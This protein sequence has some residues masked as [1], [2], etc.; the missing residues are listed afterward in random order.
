MISLIGIVD[1]E[2]TGLD[3]DKDRIVEVAIILYSLVHA[4]PI[5]SFS[6][7][8]P[9]TVHGMEAINHIPQS[10]T[11]IANYCIAEGTFL[12]LVRQSDVIV[13]HNAIFDY[14]FLTSLTASLI[15]DKLKWI[16]EPWICSMNHIEWPNSSSSKALTA[17]ALAHDVGVVSAHRAL[18]DCD[19]LSRLFTRVAEKHS[20][21]DLIEEALKPRKLFKAN[22]DYH[23]RSLASKAG[24]SWHE[25]SRYW[26][27]DETKMWLRQFNERQ[28]NEWRLSNPDLPISC[29]GEI[30]PICQE[31]C[32]D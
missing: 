25:L 13:A 28:F 4:C 32:N 6:S 3:P 12:D 5:A 14:G 7:L 20:L 30:P 2:T 9:S 1:T 24:F 15:G 23:H 21:Q 19:I 29:L 10:A 22:V 8:L 31:V 11:L 26:G 18:T 27:T 17:I 16:K